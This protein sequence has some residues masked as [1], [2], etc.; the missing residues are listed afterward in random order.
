MKKLYFYDLMKM[1]GEK[2][3]VKDLKY[4]YADQ[5]CEVKERFDEC[6]ECGHQYKT[7]ALENDEYE[8]EYDR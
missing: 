4:S 8:F 3:L 7:I 6:L 1:F 2:V 5:I